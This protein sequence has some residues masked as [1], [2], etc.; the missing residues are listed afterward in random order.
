VFLLVGHTCLM[1]VGKARRLPYSG[2]PER[3]SG[4]YCT[5]WQFYPLC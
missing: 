1:F 4:L 5:N 3:Y 2:A